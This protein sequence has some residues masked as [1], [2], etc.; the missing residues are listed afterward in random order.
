MSAS[1]HMSRLYQRMITGLLV[2][3]AFFAL[4]TVTHADQSNPPGS[5]A[6]MLEDVDGSSG[7]TIDQLRSH[8]RKI[9]DLLDHASTRVDRLADEAGGNPDGNAL[10]DAIRQELDL[11]RQWNR[12]LTAILLEVAEAR[13]ELSIR[14]RQAAAE[15]HELTTVAEEARLE[16]IALKGALEDDKEVIEDDPTDISPLDSEVR[17]QSIFDL[18]RDGTEIKA[19]DLTDSRSNIDEARRAL[20]TMSEAQALAASDI[21]AVRS[22]II[23]ALQTLAP[24]RAAPLEAE[25]NDKPEPQSNISSEDIT[26]WAAAIA[27]KLHHEGFDTIEQI[28]IDLDEGTDGSAQP[29]IEVMMI[30]SEAASKATVRAAPNHKAPAVAFIAQG[31]SILVTGK[32]FDTNWYRIEISGGRHGFVPGEFIRRQAAPDNHKIKR[33]KAS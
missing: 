21:D 19:G 13:R 18:R 25:F 23:D 1:G 14:E 5:S 29:N 3:S 17:L 30:N 20:E 8:A 15:I 9:G 32:V 31:S 4:A 10:L 11:S 33:I 16:L 2:G 22:K 12:H 27:G 6:S 24:H 26:A 28:K 7:A